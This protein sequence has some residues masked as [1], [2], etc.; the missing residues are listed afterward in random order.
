VKYY[1]ELKYF[2]NDSLHHDYLDRKHLL[3]KDISISESQNIDE[4]VTHIGYINLF[5]F[6]I[7]MV[8][9]GSY[10]LKRIIAI[11]SDLKIL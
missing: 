2:Y 3:F 6:M 4:F 5:P 10:P 9:D 7:S 11:R 1:R 8:A